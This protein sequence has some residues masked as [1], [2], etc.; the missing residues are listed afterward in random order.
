MRLGVRKNYVNFYV[1]GQ[2]VARLS[3]GKDRLPKVTVHEAYVTGRVRV[4]ANSTDLPPKGKYVPHDGETLARA[5]TCRENRRMGEEQAET[6]AGAEKRFVDRLIAANPGVID[7][8]M[9]LP[10][11]QVVTLGK[12]AAPRMDL[13]LAQTRTGEPPGIAFWEAK[14]SINKELR[15]KAK[16]G[17]TSDGKLR[18][19]MVIHQLL[20]YEQW[21]LSGNRIGEVR[22][23]YRATAEILLGFYDVFSN[24]KLP[25]PPCVGIWRTLKASRTPDVI[26]P[27]G[28]VIGNYCPRE[29]NSAE[30]PAFE[31]NKDT[32]LR[33]GHRKKLEGHAIKHEVDSENDDHALPPLSPGTVTT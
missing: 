7:L 31:R 27:P 12:R 30:A 21:M 9:G 15:A 20:K 18:G 32:F 2:S 33:D 8:E 13:V 5:E 19:P 22:G 6:Y 1:A 29:H 11:G 17:V 10:A 24:K 16:Y 25:E 3:F 26:L 4:A 14:C 23:A 28:V